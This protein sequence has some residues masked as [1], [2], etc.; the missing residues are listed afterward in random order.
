M[1]KVDCISDQQSSIEW[2]DGYKLF[3]LDGVELP[4][5]Y[6]KELSLKRCRYL[7]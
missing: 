1:M 7:K 4:K 5:I 3:H 6:G 2:R